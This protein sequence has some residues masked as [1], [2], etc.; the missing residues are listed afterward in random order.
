MTPKIYCPAHGVASGR[1]PEANQHTLKIVK[2]SKPD[3]TSEP[4]QE[5]RLLGWVQEKLKE[6]EYER[7]P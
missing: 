5:I 2:F 4:V 6:V 7:C 1:R 3:G